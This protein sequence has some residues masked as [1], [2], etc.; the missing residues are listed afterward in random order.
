ME[1][2]RTPEQFTLLTEDGDWRVFFPYE[3]PVDIPQGEPV[4][5]ERYRVVDS[6]EFDIETE[7]ATVSVSDLGIIEAEELVVYSTS[8]GDS[9]RAWSEESDTLP[10]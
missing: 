6:V 1:R 3:E 2:E 8:L 9:S 5:D 7:R 4:D 10:R